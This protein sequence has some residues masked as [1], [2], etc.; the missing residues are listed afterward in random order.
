MKCLLARNNV[1][2]GSPWSRDTHNEVIIRASMTCDTKP[3]M[4]K[5]RSSRGNF[6]L[7]KITPSAPSKRLHR[8]SLNSDLAHIKMPTTFRTSA[9]RTPLGDD[10]DIE[11][12]INDGW[13]CCRVTTFKPKDGG[14]RRSLQMIWTKDGSEKSYTYECEGDEGIGAVLKQL[15]KGG[16]LPPQK[17]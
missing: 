3:W 1:R 6:R 12:L 16:S 13:L 2:L 9:S 5:K 17:N 14:H 7:Q 11:R 15:K 4:Y 10:I 8:L